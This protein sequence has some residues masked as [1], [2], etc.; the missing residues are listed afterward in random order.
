[1][2]QEQQPAQDVLPVEK[3]A[4]SGSASNV[5]DNI[6]KQVNDIR[7]TQALSDV[8]GSGS[9]AAVKALKALGLDKLVIG[10]AAEAAEANVKPAGKSV[11]DSNPAEGHSS[12][13]EGFS[14][15]K[16]EKGGVNSSQ[17]DDYIKA[18]AI[19]DGMKLGLLREAKDT[20]LENN[21]KEGKTEKERPL[22]RIEQIITKELLQSARSGDVE[23]MKEMLATL[24]ESPKSV[25]AVLRQV[26]DSLSG[27]AHVGWERGTD[28]SGNSFVRMHLKTWDKAAEQ[29]TR[30]TVGS[31][32]TEDAYSQGWK[33]GSPRQSL[34]ASK[35]LETMFYR[36]QIPELRHFGPLPKG[37]QEPIPAELL[38]KKTI[39]K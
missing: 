30:V 7:A 5:A 37:G 34:D 38:I 4:A 23:G 19:A 29:T 32:G 28:D 11:K 18:S 22:S 17:S 13:T 8:L 3:D 39:E 15:K 16:V 2:A 6:L 10:G 12:S 36:P 1:M 14:G 31:D 21:I 24:N 33:A 27:H 9:A 25:D 26:R 35:T 20:T